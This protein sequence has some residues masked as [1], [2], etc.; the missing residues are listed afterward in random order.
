MSCATG[1]C[2]TGGCGSL[3]VHDWLENMLPPGER[4]SDNIYEVKFK[5]TRKEYFRNVNNLELVTGDYVCVES[6]RGYDVGTVTMGGQLARLQL[7]KKKIAEKDVLAI[8][9]VANQ[10]E[11]DKMCALRETEKEVLIRSRAIIAS[12]RLEMKLSEVEYQGDGTKIIFFYVADQ[13][14]DFR[15]LIKLLANDFRVRIE[16]RQIGLRQEAGL[17]GGVG[18]CGRELCC[19]SF[20]TDFKVVNTNAARYQNISLNP[21]KITGQCGRLKCCLNYELETYMDAL[22]FIPQVNQLRTEGGVAYLQKTDI[23]KRKMWFS[24]GDANWIAIDAAKVVEYKEM[25][26]RGLFPPILQAA[27]PERVKLPA[28][29]FVEVVGES[30]V[31]ERLDEKRRQ[32]NRNKKNRGNDRR[33]GGGGGGGRDDRRGGPM[34]P[35][36]RGPRPDGPPHGPENR[37]PRPDGPQRGPDNRGPRPEGPPRGPRP[38][39]PNRGPDNRGP[40]PDGPPRG[41]RPDGPNRGPDN[42]GPRPDGPPRGSRPDGPNRGPD[43][44]GPRPGP[45][46]PPEG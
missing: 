34:G 9:R 39:G 37:G 1:G 30:R 20:L 29:E 5:A 17:V 33:G 7:R 16:M 40:R 42:R 12:L 43:N 38:E 27:E 26:D 23:F 45:I 35:G 19:S 18:S 4:E 31:L 22:K 32:A 8:F 25:N 21:G 11:V 14:V 36:N 3:T 13:R 15:E 6:D 41:P 46:P 28:D 10:E 2:K 44:R 24:F